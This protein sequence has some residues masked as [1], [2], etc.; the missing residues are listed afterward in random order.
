MNQSQDPTAIGP[1]GGYG[2]RLE[3][4]VDGELTAETLEELERHAAQCRDCAE[5][6]AYLRRLKEL[7]RRSCCET[8]APRSLR[9]RISVQISSVEIRRG[10]A[11]VSRTTVTRR[12]TLGD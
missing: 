6:L 10:G 9:E 7:L 3:E 4:A 5:E 12:R 8:V 11:S 2:R 1:V